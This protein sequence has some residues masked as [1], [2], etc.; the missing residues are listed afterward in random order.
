[1]LSVPGDEARQDVGGVFRREWTAI[2][3]GPCSVAAGAFGEPGLSK[4]GIADIVAP[5]VSISHPM[6]DIVVR[7]SSCP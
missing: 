3:L 7:R 4:I 6:Y 1:M 5:A 2:P